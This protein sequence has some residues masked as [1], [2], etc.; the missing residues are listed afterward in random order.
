MLGDIFE[1]MTS[2]SLKMTK[3]CLTVIFILKFLYHRGLELQ[4]NVPQKVRIYKKY[5]SGQNSKIDKFSNT[6]TK[7]THFSLFLA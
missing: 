6:V 2:Q 1:K 7:F 5:Q 4:K 3:K